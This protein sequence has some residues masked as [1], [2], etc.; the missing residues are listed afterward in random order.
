MTI[1]PIDIKRDILTSIDAGVWIRPKSKVSTASATYITEHIDDNYHDFLLMWLGFY[2]L[3]THNM[4][5]IK[6]FKG[7]Y[8]PY[9]IVSSD[10]S[11]H[12]FYS[13]SY[14]WKKQTFECSYETSFT[15][16]SRH[17]RN[18]YG[19]NLLHEIIKNGETLNN[20]I[21]II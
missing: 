6:L 7:C 16:L 21:K 12:I 17:L 14:T 11:S 9:G 1:K 3:P 4:P 5:T 2:Y 18:R 15:G 19:F 10:T 13:K 8:T 20:G